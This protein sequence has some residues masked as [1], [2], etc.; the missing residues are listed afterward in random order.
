M[1]T[2]LETGVLLAVLVALFGAARLM[3]AIR[4][5]VVNA[6]VGLI[7]FLIAGWLGVDVAVD[8]VALLV[9]ALGGLPGAVLVV[10]LAVLDVAFVP[11]AVGAGVFGGVLAVV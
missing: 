6:V 11:A 9:V 7:V 10:L 2:A 5:F 8:W 1:V 4:P 3:R